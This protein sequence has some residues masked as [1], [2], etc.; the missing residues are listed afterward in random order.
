MKI[1]FNLG[2]TLIISVPESGD[3]FVIAS[4]GNT[5]FINS[6][7]SDD[8][9]REGVL[10]SCSLI[11]VGKEDYP[12]DKIAKVIVC[13]SCGKE[14]NFM[15]GEMKFMQQTFKDNYQ[16][17]VR[18]PLCRKKRCVVQLSGSRRRTRT[19]GDRFNGK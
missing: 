3:E 5:L 8:H 12:N 9:G 2:E 15:E 16:D 10:Y 14:F 18:C 7:E 11:G 4:S 6:K 19:N 1:E 13:N 17:P